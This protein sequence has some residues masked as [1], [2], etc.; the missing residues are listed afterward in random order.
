[1]AQ[2]LSRAEAFV[3]L[4]AMLQSGEEPKLLDADVNQLLDEAARADSAGIAPSD[5]GWTETWSLE[6]AAAEG[7]R[8]KAGKVAGRFN[9]TTDGDALARAQIFAHCLSMAD[10]YA[11]KVVSAIEIHSPRGSTV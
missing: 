4:S 10:R 8:R 11:R 6:S 3:R 5:A 2:Q 1:M 9:V 7:W